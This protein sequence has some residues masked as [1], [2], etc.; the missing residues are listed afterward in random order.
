M[1]TADGTFVT[2]AVPPW[3][4]FGPGLPDDVQAGSDG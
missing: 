4:A 1:L 3:L 2:A